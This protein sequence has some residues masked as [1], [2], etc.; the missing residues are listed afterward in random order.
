MM[1]LIAL[2]I[3]SQT[4]FLSAGF[5]C[6]QAQTQSSCPQAQTQSSCPQAQTQ[7]SCQGNRKQKKDSQKVFR[8]VSGEQN[9]KIEV[10]KKCPQSSCPQ[11]SC[12]KK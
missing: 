7:S 12:K 8:A 4:Q 3:I 5:Q 6:P 9:I 10:Q 11:S 2:I 1:K